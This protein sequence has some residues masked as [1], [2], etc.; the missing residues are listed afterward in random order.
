VRVLRFT[1]QYQATS[2]PVDLLCH[3]RSLPKDSRGKAGARPALPRNC[4]ATFIVAQPGYLANRR[5]R[6]YLRGRGRLQESSDVS[7]SGRRS[8]TR[9]HPVAPGPFNPRSL[10][11]PATVESLED[12]QNK[13]QRADDTRSTRARSHATSFAISIAAHAC[14]FAALIYFA[15]ALSKPSTDLVLAYLVEIGDGVS[16]GS[17]SIRAGARTMRSVPIR[18]EAGPLLI[19]SRPT[20]HKTVHRSLALRRSTHEHEAESPDS[21]LAS[22]AP[23]VS[24]KSAPGADSGPHSSAETE[25]SG[26]S[27]N[28]GDGSGSG[29]GNS[30]G[31]GDGEGSSVAHADYGINPPPVYPVDARR[32][33]QQGTV[34]IRALIG[35]DGSVEHAEIAES[36]GFDSLDD[37]ALDTVRRRWRFVP[38]RR[39]NVPV[40]SWVLVP[41][42]FALTEAHASR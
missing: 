11:R 40:E 12:A 3:P 42:R 17:G 21:K 14:A 4:K 9:P 30:T 26:A 22:V 27:T 19:P 10:G 33:E 1:Q 32:R 7:E 6:K 25:T 15:P 28:A 8:S 36:C 31:S 16:G 37:S 38:A 2:R 34:T 5:S 39:D 23:S 18:L 29:A 20:P 35:A 24:A 41:I 13:S